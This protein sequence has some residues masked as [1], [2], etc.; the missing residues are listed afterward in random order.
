MAKKRPRCN[1]RKW[2]RPNIRVEIVRRRAASRTANASVIGGLARPGE[3]V[4]RPRRPS[5][6]GVG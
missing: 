1:C 5:G 6:C 2:F 4:R 3:A